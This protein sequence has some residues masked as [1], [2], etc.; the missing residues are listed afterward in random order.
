MR[1]GRASRLTARRRFL[2]IY[3]RG[4]RVGRPYFVLFALPGATPVSRL[5]ITATKKFGGA[6]ERNRFKRVVRE[7]FRANRSGLPPIDLVVNAK[8][9][10]KDA[11]RA[12]LERSFATALAEIARRVGR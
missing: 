9:A 7:L 3:E 10:S 6:V 5:G 11:N 8:S 4:Q 1:F 12:E 2:E